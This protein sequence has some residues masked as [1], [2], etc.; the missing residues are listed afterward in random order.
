MLVGAGEDIWELAPSAKRQ[1][2]VV[3]RSAIMEMSRRPEHGAQVSSNPKTA[4]DPDLF[5]GG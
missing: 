4:L 2:N 3:D 1:Q 5:E